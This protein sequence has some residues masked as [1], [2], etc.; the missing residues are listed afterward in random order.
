MPS[1]R[2]GAQRGVPGSES[3]NPLAWLPG[4]QV[5]RVSVNFDSLESYAPSV[6]LLTSAGLTLLPLGASSGVR[7]AN[8]KTTLLDDPKRLLSLHDASRKS[9]LSLSLLS[10]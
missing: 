6:P 8:A 4:C 10:T 3:D 9:D 5:P 1:H 2:E 7:D